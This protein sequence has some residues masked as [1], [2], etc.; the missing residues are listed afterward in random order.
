VG[1]VCHM[2]DVF[3]F[4]N[5]IPGRVAFAM[6]AVGSFSCADGAGASDAMPPS[7]STN[8][9]VAQDC[10]RLQSQ[11]YQLTRSADPSAFASAAGLDLDRMGVRVVIE[12]AV[13]ADLPARYAG[14]VETRY[15]NLVQAR[16]PVAHLCLLARDPVVASISMPTRGF[17]GTRQP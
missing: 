17:P 12:L 2:L 1:G 7:R 8:S 16:V 14:S 5:R 9:D 11:L 6:L 4:R 3:E 13:G 15:A 10:S